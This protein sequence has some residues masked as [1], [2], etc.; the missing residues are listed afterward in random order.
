LSLF[1]LT[2]SHHL[3]VFSLIHVGFCLTALHL[4]I[5]DRLRKELRQMPRGEKFKVP[6]GAGAVDID[7]EAIEG[8]RVLRQLAEDDAQNPVVIRHRA[9][10]DRLEQQAKDAIA[11]EYRA[12]GGE[13]DLGVLGRPVSKIVWAGDGFQQTFEYGSIKTLSYQSPRT[14]V[15]YYADGVPLGN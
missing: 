7:V 4:M 9:E 6:V 2:G 10:L 5:H 12:R 1:G 8:F 13:S 15:A 11:K 3:K 14:E